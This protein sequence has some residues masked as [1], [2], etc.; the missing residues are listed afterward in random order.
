MYDSKPKVSQGTAF[1]SSGPPKI[2]ATGTSSRSL[3][4]Q[5]RLI[6]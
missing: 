4:Y 5:P 1:I 3:P 2:T 6:P